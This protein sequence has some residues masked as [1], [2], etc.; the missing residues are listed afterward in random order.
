MN[1]NTFLRYVTKIGL[2]GIVCVGCCVCAGAFAIHLIVNSD[3]FRH[4]LE[5]V[6]STTASALTIGHLEARYP[7]TI[8]ATD[9][10]F[11]SHMG[12]LDMVLS[13]DN[14]G[15]T[16]GLLGALRARIDDLMLSG[17][18]V[19]LVPSDSS[20]PREKHTSKAA[21]PFPGSIRLPR[22]L[23]RFCNARLLDGEVRIGSG[24]HEYVLQGI[25]IVWTAFPREQYGDLELSLATATT[26]PSR[27]VLHVEKDT[28]VVSQGR[29]VLP[30]VDIP[31]IS[32]L[33]GMR[34]LAA[35]TLSLMLHPPP[36]QDVPRH[37][38]CIDVDAKGLVLQS[39]LGVRG[40]LKA[41]VEVTGSM[42]DLTVHGTVVSEDLR[43]ARGASPELGIRTDLA[44]SATFAR[45]V[46]TAFVAKSERMAAT[47]FGSWAGS[48]AY[49]PDRIDWQIAADQ[50]ILDKIEKGLVRALL[51]EPVRSFSWK[52]T[53]SLASQGSIAL[54]NGR[55]VAGVVSLDARDVAFNSPDFQKMAERVN[56][57]LKGRAMCTLDGVPADLSA[58]VRITGGEVVWGG[59]YADLAKLQ[60]TLRV[61]V[62]LRSLG[63]HLHVRSL[64]VDLKEIGQVRAKGVISSDTHGR[65]ILTEVEASE[66]SLQGL[67]RCLVQD[68]LSGAV[69]WLNGCAASGSLSVAA[70]YASK[71]GSNGIQG[72]LSLRKASVSVPAL[73]VSVVRVEADIPFSVGTAGALH[74]LGR[75]RHNPIDQGRITV[76]DFSYKDITIPLLAAE[77]MLAENTFTLTKPLEVTLSGGSMRIENGR[78]QGVWSGTGKGEASLAFKNI[79]L[80]PVCSSLFGRSGAGQV[81][82]W[83]NAITSGKDSIWLTGAIDYT[84]GDGRIG[85]E[86]IDMQILPHGASSGTCQLG[87]SRL[88]I[89]EAFRGLLD[90]PYDMILEGDLSD[91]KLADGALT[92]SGSLTLTGLDG[93]V[94]C[95]NMAAEGLFGPAPEVRSD[96]VIR[97]ID[98]AQL[99]GP[100]QFGSISGSISG[101]IKGLVMGFTFPYARAFTADIHTVKK[102]G[103][104][105]KIDATAVNKLARVGGS[106]G[107]ATALSTG[108]YRYFDEYYYDRMGIRLSLEDGWLDIHG[109]PKGKEEYLIL[110]G[111]R[112]PSISMPIKVMT[113]NRKVW[114][115]SWLRDIMGAS[116]GR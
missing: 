79:A 98:L 33:V 69:P 68:G 72:M 82:G 13:V 111:L 8:A 112:L 18:R 86:H 38:L 83:F 1:G 44:I 34:P 74:A 97:D 15:V 114:F 87:I 110:R 50:V 103:V 107:L 36:S 93:M 57:T 19:R 2:V 51:P 115:A 53:V 42:D 109:I 60:P 14:V 90:I 17:V 67:T 61:D 84:A 26:Q 29:L 20:Q 62:G 102:K 80:G 7:L 56:F 3:G 91:I 66:L 32:S 58:D 59:M 5:R 92:A 54:Q 22:W 77:F 41:T 21:M 104:S 6:M 55:S 99:T 12:G 75:G 31:A 47:P 63:P 113:P 40:S 85:I 96:I 11:T 28:I 49:R 106:K 43:I 116:G 88:A 35:G 4:Y 101:E 9:V 37:G 39:V 89:K 95:S 108:V 73:G 65:A 105:Q 16:V 76:S 23:W 30:S 45:G 81:S 71:E 46:P 64:A 10:V 94:T 52:G 24:D 70:S 78:Y 27:L 25:C 48:I 100:F